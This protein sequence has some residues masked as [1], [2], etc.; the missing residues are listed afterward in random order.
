ME[1]FKHADDLVA[2]LFPVFIGLTLLV[3]VLMDHNLNPQRLQAAFG[4]P[5]PGAAAGPFCQ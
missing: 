2:R 5:L 3:I 4:A 1:R